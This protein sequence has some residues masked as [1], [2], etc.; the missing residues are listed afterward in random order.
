M[1]AQNTFMKKN[2][3]LIL[4]A[5]I[6]IGVCS[7]LVK[8]AEMAVEVES[9]ELSNAQVQDHNE[10]SGQKVVAFDVEGAEAK[11]EIE[12]DPGEYTVYLI[13]SGRDEA[14]DAVNVAVGKTK[15][16]VYPSEHPNLGESGSFSLNVIKKKK[17]PVSIT[18][19]EPG[20]LLDRLV[21]KSASAKAET[22]P[23]ETTNSKEDNSP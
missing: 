2:L 5:A 20:V 14:H 22:T 17:Y 21:F 16:R 6:A 15:K 12:L 13:M 1:K 4:V 8:A 18:F 10:A 7:N 19:G 23:A 3:T 11:G 9:L